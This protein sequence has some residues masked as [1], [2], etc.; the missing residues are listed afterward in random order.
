MFLGRIP[1]IF[2]H[3]GLG[4][5]VG[6]RCALPALQ[7]GNLAFSK[8]DEGFQETIRFLMIQ[9]RHSWFY[10]I[11]EPGTGRKHKEF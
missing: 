7:A 6:R 2:S 4:A 9:K 11:S 5:S 10:I 1:P 3:H 8:E